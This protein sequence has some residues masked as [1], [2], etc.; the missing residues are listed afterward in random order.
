MVE[1]ELAYVA[2]SEKKKK[3]CWVL[4]SLQVGERSTSPRWDEGFYFLVRDPKEETLTVK[5]IISVS[6]SF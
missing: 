5:V 1:G 6:V 2:K 3:D 4:F